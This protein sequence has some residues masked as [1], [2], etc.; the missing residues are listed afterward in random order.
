MIQALEIHEFGQLKV[1]GAMGPTR[2]VAVSNDAIHAK[3]AIG[4]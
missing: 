1:S 3:L 2:Y 4:G